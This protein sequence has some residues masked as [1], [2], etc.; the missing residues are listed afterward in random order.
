MSR[1]LAATGLAAL[2]ALAVGA[3]FA[4]CDNPFALPPALSLPKDTTYTLFSMT[5]TPVFEPSAYDMVDSELVRTDRTGIFDFALDMPDSLGDTI[6]LLLPP[7]ALGLG[8]D[9]G[10]QITQTPFD[11]ITYAPNSGYQQAVGQKLVVGMVLLASSRTQTC[12]YN[13]A[14]PVYAKLE[15]LAIDKIARS[16]TF[17]MLLDDNCGYRSL[18]ADS[19]PPTN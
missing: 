5:G 2:C 17:H 16:V 8:R 10:L 14:Y 18:Q 7:G 4:A 11:S 13:L 19:L 6:P 12:N 15:V 3:A 1:P 9:G